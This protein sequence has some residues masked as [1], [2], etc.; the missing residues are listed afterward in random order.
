MAGR[1]G[2]CQSLSDLGALGGSAY[3]ERIL[4]RCPVITHNIE[5]IGCLSES[6][7]ER[8]ADWALDGQ[9]TDSTLSLYI[10]T[11]INLNQT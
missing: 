11:T 1:C 6:C 5:T 8:A 2:S 7:N 3:T 9:L 4:D 10:I